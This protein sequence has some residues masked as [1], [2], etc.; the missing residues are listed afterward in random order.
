MGVG[1]AGDDAGGD[2]GPVAEMTGRQNVGGAQQIGKAVNHRFIFPARAVTQHDGFRTQPRLVIQH[3]LGDGIQGV[4]PGNTLPFATALGAD[5]AHRMGQPVGMVGELGGGQALAA[6]S[7]VVDG[8]VRIT[9]NFGHLTFL[10]VNQD[11]APPMA[12]PAMAFDNGIVT[13]NF[14]FPLDIGKFKFSHLNN[15]FAER[16]KGV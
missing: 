2:P 10:G 9:G 1:S 13:V 6:H 8:T 7:A 3:P 15:L 12:H 5:P 14:H 4:I 11:P 16:Y